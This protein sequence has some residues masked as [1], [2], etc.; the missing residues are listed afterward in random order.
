MEAIKKRTIYH[1][2]FHW[3]DFRL[4]VFVEGSII[5]L[6][7]G[8]V[9]VMFRYS[10]EA[11]GTLRGQIYGYLKTG[12][13][14]P[15]VAWFIVLIL[16]GVI[17]GLIVRRDPMARGSGIPEVEGILAGQ[18]KMKW[19]SVIVSKFVGGVLAIGAGLSLGR[20]GPSI[21]LGAAVGQ[22]FSRLL[23]RR[24]MEEKYLITSG[25][26]AGL[27]AAFN[28]PLAGAIFALEEVHKTFSPAILMSAVAASLTSD[29]V[30]EWV[31]GMK[32]IF[33]FPALAVL[34]FRYY[35]YLIGLGVITGLF[36][37]LFNR[38]LVKTLNTYDAISFLPRSLLPVL[39]LLAGGLLG[40]VL[41]Q[42]LGGGHELINSLARIHFSLMM[43]IVLVVVK[44]AFT[45]ISYGS[46]VPGGI[47]LPLL[48][49]G[50]LTGDIYGHLIVAYFS[51]NPQYV[52]NFIVLA[53][54]AYFAAIVKAPITGSILI[55]EMTGSFQHLLALI[56]VSMTAYIVT[57]VLNSK[58]IYEEL[59]ER[60]LT[61]KG[62]RNPSLGAEGKS[63]AGG[64][65][66]ITEVA[67]CLG[68]QLEGKRIKDVSWPAH[69][70]I[71]SI[72]RGDEEI[73]P[74]GNTRIL[75]GDNMYTLVDE[76]RLGEVKAVFRHLAGEPDA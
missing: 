22:G 38:T 10:L 30:T 58:P 31:F 26:S 43:L 71:V 75:A 28:A 73:I 36:G 24:R 41:P 44:F 51:A 25:A 62:K 67:V 32:P 2:I 63:P 70:L 27:A 42:T 33:A 39:P 55:T 72:R 61:K 53:M 49:V 47:F 18:L 29:F 13:M 37:V 40:L 15:I 17:V 20:E 35:G 66:V 14:I 5:G 52:T 74:N 65:Q 1:D 54:A 48:V 64:K 45:M 19:P 3:K 4:K 60:V 59:L 7:A 69:S 34:P 68:S 9:T 11:A 46:G 23:G 57:D 50:A 12:G 76:A 21:Q 8:I 16:I 56:A 6:L